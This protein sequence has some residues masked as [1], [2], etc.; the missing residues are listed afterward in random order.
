MSYDAI[1]INAENPVED[2]LHVTGLIQHASVADIAPIECI[3]SGVYALP[4]GSIVPFLESD[5]DQAQGQCISE[6]SPS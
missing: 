2:H 1:Y 5:L 4:E 3:L 6:E